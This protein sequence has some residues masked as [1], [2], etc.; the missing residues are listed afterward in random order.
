MVTSV[1]KA[2]DWGWAA[3]LRGRVPQR[4]GRG[5]PETASGLKKNESFDVLDYG[6][7]C[8]L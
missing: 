4:V 1:P 5:G 2:Q 8:G 7:K 6:L 3:S